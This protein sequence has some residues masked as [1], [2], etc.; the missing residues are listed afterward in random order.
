M[1]TLHKSM[2]MFLT[3]SLLLVL[4]INVS[5]LGDREPPVAIHNSVS[6]E[7]PS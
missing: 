3:I 6:S 1:K 7:K 2:V 4:T 5:P